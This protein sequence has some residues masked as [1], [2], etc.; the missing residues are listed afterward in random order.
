MAFAENKVETYLCGR[1]SQLGG[2]CHKWTGT[3]NCPDRIV[4]LPCGTVWFVEVKTVD[5]D[6]SHGQSRFIN[7]LSNLNA[8]VATVYGITGVIN[9]INEHIIKS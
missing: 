7:R 5:G 6:L 8:N 9:W 4:I 1:I 3:K 2:Q